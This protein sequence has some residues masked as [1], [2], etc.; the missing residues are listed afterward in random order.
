MSPSRQT[1]PAGTE[2]HSRIASI[3]S[4]IIDLLHQRRGAMAELADLRRA[5]RAPRVQLARENEVVRRYSEE[6]GDSGTRLALLL[7]RDDPN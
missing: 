6:L 5:G 3:D 7:L 4:A 2:P 1:H